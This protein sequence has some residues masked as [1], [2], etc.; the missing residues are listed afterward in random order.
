MAELTVQIKWL[1]AVLYQFIRALWAERLPSNPVSYP[2]I[3]R[4]I[5]YTDKRI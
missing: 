1:A 2:S 5:P 3:Y 4:A